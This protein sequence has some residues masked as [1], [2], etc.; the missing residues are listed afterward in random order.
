ME[1]QTKWFA[2]A[3][4]TNAN[5]ATATIGSG[6][7]GAVVV[8]Y[9]NVGT[10]GNSYDIEVVIAAGANAAMKAELDDTTITITLGTGATPGVV[11][12]AKNTAKLIATAITAL[13]PFTAAKSGTGVDSI[14]EATEDNVA[15]T[16]GTYCTPFYGD[17]AWLYIGSTYYYCSKPCDI[18]STDAWKTV[19]FTDA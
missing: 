9:D 13:T 19:V 17:E 12:A 1:L 7:N 8:T 3:T 15:F 14:S 16:G 2:E 6:T 11:E 10:E 5:K 4:P 18:Y